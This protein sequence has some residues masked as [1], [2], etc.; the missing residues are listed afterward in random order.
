MTARFLV[1]DVFRLTS[2]GIFV[3]HGRILE[4]TVR[5]G[6][7]VQ[8]PPGLDAPVD[9]IEVVLLSVNEGRENPALTFKY[10]DESQVARWQALGLV[11][12]TLVLEDGEAAVQ[13]PDSAV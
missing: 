9:A 5:R 12:Q 6:Q 13:D 4:G 10:R 7:R 8:A 11:G 2:R 1:E 3:V